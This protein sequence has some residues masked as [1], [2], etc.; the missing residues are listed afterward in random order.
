MLRDRKLY[1]RNYEGIYLKC[2]GCEEV[3]KVLEH[4]HDKYGTGHDSAKATAHMILRSGYLAYNIQR[5]FWTC[6]HLPHLSDKC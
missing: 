6:A 4:F 2:L 3:K 1:K 5:Y